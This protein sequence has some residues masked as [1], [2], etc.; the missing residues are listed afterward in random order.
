MVVANSGDAIF[1]P[2]VGAEM[3]VLKRKILP[4]LAF[5]GVVL[6]NGSPSALGQIG[7]PAPP[8]LVAAL[9]LDDAELFG[10]H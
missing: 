3:G 5:G 6:A 4:G 2:A 7:S 10:V 8:M 1:A 9:S